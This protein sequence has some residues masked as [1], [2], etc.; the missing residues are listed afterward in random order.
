MMEGFFRLG[1]VDRPEALPSA[2]IV[3]AVHQPRSAA[4]FATSGRRSRSVT[5]IE[6]RV[7]SL[8][9][10]VSSQ[11]SLTARRQ[12]TTKYRRRRVLSHT[13]TS[14]RSPH[15]PSHPDHPAR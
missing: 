10:V 5:I 4:I 8:A 12:G 13:R 15:A 7:T 14:T 1:D 11:P 6:L 9:R 3:D 2:E